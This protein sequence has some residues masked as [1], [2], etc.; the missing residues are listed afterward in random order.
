MK[1]ID[2]V[3]ESAGIEFKGMFSS[4]GVLVI[5]L[6]SNTHTFTGTSS[7]M[8]SFAGP[9]SIEIKDGTMELDPA[10]V[11]PSH[12]GIQVKNGAFLWLW[13]TLTIDGKSK[14]FR[15]L[16]QVVQTGQILWNNP[17]C[18]NVNVATI[19]LRIDK[20]RAMAYVGDPT[21]TNLVAGGLLVTKDGN[22]I[23]EAGTFT[24]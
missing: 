1:F 14:A 22:I 21:T 17:T 23:T 11:N 3:T 13:N 20:A 16:T 19:A 2:D 4:G 6:D 8:M 10:S 12:T 18:S 7:A 9:F 15:E 24:P 5:D